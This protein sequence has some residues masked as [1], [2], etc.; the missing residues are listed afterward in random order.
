M[1][2]WLVLPA[3]GMAVV[4]SASCGEEKQQRQQQAADYQ[5]MV[6]GQKIWCSSDST[7]RV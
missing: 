2:D 1:T 5:T 4:L 6:V 7:R 3:V